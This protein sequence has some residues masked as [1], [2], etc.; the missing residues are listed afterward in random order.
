MKFW[1]RCEHSSLALP[2]ADPEA[3]AEVRTLGQIVQYLVRSA[4]QTAV[5]A[6]APAVVAAAPAAASPA[7]VSAPAPGAAYDT[8]TLS[9]ALLNVVSEKTGYPVEMLELDIGYG[10]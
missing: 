4:P 8:E 6:A 9:K 2:Q 5:P 1:E 10:S 7:P 3:F